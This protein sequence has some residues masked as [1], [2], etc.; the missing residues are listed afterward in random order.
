MAGEEI[1]VPIVIVAIVLLLVIWMLYLSCFVVRQSE[2]M[3]IERLGR[4][5]RILHE[6]LNFVRPF[7]DRPREFS[8]RRTYIG[9]DGQIYD[10]TITN[11]R[12]DLRESVFNFLRTEVFTKDGLLL[13]VN[14]LM[15]YRITDIKAAVYEVDDLLSALS[16][17]AQTQLKEVFGNMTFTEALE[18]QTQINEYLQREFSHLFAGWGLTVQRLELLDLTPKQATRDYMK[19]QMVAERQRRGEFIRSEGAKASMKLRADGKKMM[20]LNR[21]I[22][23]EEATR[24]QSE[25]DAGARIELARAESAALEAL[26]ASIKADGSSQNE[27]QIAQRY[28]EFF[29]D[30]A[31][32]SENKEVYLPYHIQALQGLVSRLEPVFGRTEQ[33][34]T[35]AEFLKAP[36]PSAAAAAA[37]PLI[38]FGVA[39][40]GGPA[41]SATPGTFRELD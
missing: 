16:N 8:W 34:P 33:D 20:L 32:Q 2:G 7:I 24:K 27:Y 10:E 25:G 21:G 17:T 19:K 4:F 41:Q 3:V 9:T 6:G 31:E 12:I 22:A 40:P 26:T 18:S 14:S 23:E 28:L 15:Y 1:W 30:M 39:P 11:S 37:A 35:R 29:R 38:D 5:N 36:G 13:D